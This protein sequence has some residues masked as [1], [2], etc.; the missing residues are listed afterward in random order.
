MDRECARSDLQ[1]HMC[2]PAPHQMRQPA[3]RKDGCERVVRVRNVGV[4]HVGQVGQQDVPGRSQRQAVERA[5]PDRGGGAFQLERER[6]G[7]DAPAFGEA[8]GRARR[9]DA[10]RDSLDH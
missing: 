6:P 7:I 2:S 8:S 5:G 9:V 3:P 4:L 10:V 1:A